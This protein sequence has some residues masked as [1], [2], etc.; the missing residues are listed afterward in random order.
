MSSFL[1]GENLVLD[2]GL[3]TS[4]PTSFINEVYDADE[5]PTPN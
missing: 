2:G 4:L 3:T 1:T 5:K